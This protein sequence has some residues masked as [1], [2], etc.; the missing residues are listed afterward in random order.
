MVELYTYTKIVKTY[1]PTVVI[2]K[3]QISHKHGWFYTCQKQK[4]EYS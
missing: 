2:G 4:I 3:K 1:R